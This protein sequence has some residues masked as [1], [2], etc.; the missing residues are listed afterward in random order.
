MIQPKIKEATK[1]GTGSHIILDRE[2]VGKT[3]L[4]LPE[5]SKYILVNVLKQYHDA[6]ES[7]INPLLN[8]F[9]SKKE[10]IAIKAIYKDLIGKNVKGYNVGVYKKFLKSSY[11]NLDKFKLSDISNILSDIENVLPK[12]LKE[13]LLGEYYKQLNKSGAK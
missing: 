9:L 11:N 1:F 10:F 3:F 12:R 2:D 7:C 6:I 5:S 4:V 13:K 8:E